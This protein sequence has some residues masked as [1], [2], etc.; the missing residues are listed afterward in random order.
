MSHGF[1]FF[2]LLQ[3]QILSGGYQANPPEG[4]RIKVGAGGSEAFLSYSG[5]INGSNGRHTYAPHVQHWQPGDPDGGPTGRLKG[6]IGAVNYLSQYVNA[7]YIVVYTANGGDD[8]RVH[9]WVNLSTK[10]QLDYA[11]L[12][13]WRIVLQH[14]NTKGME[15]ML[16]MSEQENQWYVHQHWNY[17]REFLEFFNDL[18]L[19]SFCLGEENAY[20]N[21]STVT[22]LDFMRSHAGGRPVGIHTRLNNLTIAQSILDATDFISIQASNNRFD[23]WASVHGNKGI[24]LFADE[25]AG[26]YDG[27]NDIPELISIW[28][29]FLDLGGNGFSLYP[30]SSEAGSSVNGCND[31]ECNDY[32]LLQPVLEAMRTI[33]FDYKATKQHLADKIIGL[34][35]STFK[36][37]QDINRDGALD[38]ADVVGSGHQ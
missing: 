31:V 33:H 32:S 2:L 13:D 24:A 19:V 34:Q 15:V 35:P 14:A 12:A 8:G 9:P 22:H 26:G 29:E 7:L 23:D 38:I 18:T 6:I 30:G 28:R 11:K 3:L 37:T 20:T 36:N 16:L 17:Y 27:P 4:R 25:Q 5:F 10:S 21:Q 1:W